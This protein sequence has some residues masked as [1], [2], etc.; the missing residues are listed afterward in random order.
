LYSGNPAIVPTNGKITIP[1]GTTAPVSCPVGTYCDTAGT[2]VPK[3]CPSGTYSGLTGQTQAAACIPCEPGTYCPTVGGGSYTVCPPGTYCPTQGGSS[4]TQCPIANIC[5]IPRLQAANP[6]PPGQLCDT[7]GEITPRAPCPP[8][9]YSTGGAGSSC[10]PCP[11]G[12]YGAGQSTTSQCSGV[13]PAG[14]YCPPGTT[15]LGASGNTPTPCPLGYYC[16]AGTGTCAAG[17]YFLDGVCLT[18]C[19]AGMYSKG[20][21]PFCSTCAAPAGQ[22]CSGGTTQFTACP[23]GYTCDGGTSIPYKYSCMEG[24]LMGTQCRTGPYGYDPAIRQNLYVSTP[25]TS[26][27]ER[28]SCVGINYVVTDPNVNTTTLTIPSVV[29]GGTPINITFKSILPANHAIQFAYYGQ[30]FGSVNSTYVNTTT[31][32]V[33][34]WTGTVPGPQI[35]YAYGTYTIKIFNNTTYSYVSGVESQVN[36]IP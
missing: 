26:T 23:S 18:G 11:S 35:G 29:R 24:T 33:S 2:V 25:C 15:P 1:T 22:Y 5:P 28:A 27:A 4:P 14:Y 13:C 9:T 16:P 34:T 6:C 21:E 12:Y 36:I 7:V 17:T 31:N 8:G 20:G 32:G 30:T 10:T 3:R 19:P